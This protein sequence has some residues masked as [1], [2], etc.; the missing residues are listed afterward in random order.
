MYS[1]VRHPLYVA[2]F[3]VFLGFVLV[4]KSVAFVFLATIAFVVYYERIVL[5]E[6]QFLET[7][8]G[9]E[10]SDWAARTPAVIPRFRAWAAPNLPFSWRAALQ[11]EYHGI[12]LV[13]IV[14]FFCKLSEGLVL[15]QQA[16]QSWFASERAYVI[17]LLL[18]SLFYFIARYV[19]KRTNWLAVAGRGP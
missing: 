5:A 11:R 13:G 10:F 3:V 7:N 2:N 12:L 4:V 16:I 9:E 1:L 15:R 6:E 18:C 14:F 8:Y 17:M 19:R